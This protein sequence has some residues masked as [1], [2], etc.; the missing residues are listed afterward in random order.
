M[1]AFMRASLIHRI[2]SL[3]PGLDELA[4]IRD[5]KN[6]DNHVLH[7]VLHCGHDGEMVSSVS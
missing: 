4:A 2:C 7:V 5:R 3:V 6:S 1:G